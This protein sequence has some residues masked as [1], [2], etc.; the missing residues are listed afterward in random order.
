M[1]TKKVGDFS[2]ILRNM[3][4]RMPIMSIMPRFTRS[5]QVVPTSMM[6]ELASNRATSNRAT[7]NR[8]TSN[9]ATSNRATSNPAKSIEQL[10]NTLESIEKEIKA[11]KDNYKK[12]KE[13]AITAWKSGNKRAARA[14]LDLAKKYIKRVSQLE[15]NKL[16]TT[17]LLVA[18]KSATTAAKAFEKLKSRDASQT[19]LTSASIK[20]GKIM[21]KSRRRI[22]TRRKR[23]H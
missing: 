11:Y 15:N 10:Q 17:E 9:R 16:Q 20:G 3:T 14:Q 4:L 8:A 21:R 19:S 23:R 5:R 1:T 12:K 7:S 6:S 13:N 22:K 2:R 18:L